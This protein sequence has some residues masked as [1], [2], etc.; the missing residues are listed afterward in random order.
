VGN[1]YERFRFASS[2]EADVRPDTRAVPDQ[3]NDEPR[4]RSDELPFDTLR[5]DTEL[6]RLRDELT[7]LKATL[8]DREMA[9]AKAALDAEGA[10]ERWQEEAQAA[11]LKAEQ[12]WMAREASRVAEAEAKW[13]RHSSRA[14]AEAT[15]RCEAA[16][17]VLEQ[18][19][20]ERGH[21]DVFASRAEPVDEEPRKPRANL[22]RDVLIVGALAALAITA[23]P[24]AEPFL[25]QSWQSSIASVTSDRG[26]IAGD[27]STTTLAPATSPDAAARRS[28]VVLH[29]VNVRADPSAAARVVSTLRRGLKVLVIEQRGNWTSVQIEG[30][31]ANAR[32]LGWVYGS[33]LGGEADYKTAQQVQSK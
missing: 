32:P 5:P 7:T 14:L 33:F 10:R 22:L 9:L 23:Y 3:P 13:R 18:L 28:A 27:S 2:A 29:D 21:D 31:K 12:D 8:A 16:E 4:L 15:A 6:H 25:P 24:S 30:D 19:K 1:K 17:A 20:R 26:Q 11:L